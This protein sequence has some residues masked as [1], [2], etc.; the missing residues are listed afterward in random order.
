[1][2]CG[3]SFTEQPGSWASCLQA[4]LYHQAVLFGTGQWAVMLCNWEV[5]G[6][7]SF[8]SSQLPHSGVVVCLR[9]APRVQL[10]G[11]LKCATVVLANTYH[12]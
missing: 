2:T 9:A 7:G 5:V 10:C 4:C 3:S 1:M 6:G 12:T 11:Q 8:C